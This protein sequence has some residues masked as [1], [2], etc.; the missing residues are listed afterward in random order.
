VRFDHALK[1]V[2]DSDVLALT[3]KMIGDGED[4]TKI[5]GR[6]APLNK[7]LS[8]SRAE[9]GRSDWEIGEE[10]SERTFCGEETV[11]KVKP[12]NDGADVEGSTDRVELVIGPRDL[13]S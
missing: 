9:L 2:L 10:W 12:T 5:V 13:G 11:V 6:V 4:G 8:I 1:D 7:R 3:R